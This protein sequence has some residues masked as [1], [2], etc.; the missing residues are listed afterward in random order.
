MYQLKKG[1]HEESIPI[2]LSLYKMGKTQVNVQVSATCFSIY[3][4]ELISYFP[5]VAVRTW[6]ISVW[7]GYI[8][9]SFSSVPFIVTALHLSSFFLIHFFWAGSSLS[10]CALVSD[11]HFILSSVST[12]RILGVVLVFVIILNERPGY[13][14]LRD[15]I[16]FSQ[17]HDIPLWKCSRANSATVGRDQCYRNDL[18]V[19]RYS[20]SDPVLSDPLPLS[21][22]FSP[23]QIECNYR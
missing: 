19:P 3:C 12:W 15:Y 23:K 22:E 18:A 9:V 14:V 4:F 17:I 7:H 10:I 13:G 1:F 6:V 5:I 8:F 21:T 16:P 20:R 11:F 2:L